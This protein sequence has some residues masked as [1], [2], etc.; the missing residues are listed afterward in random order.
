M[1]YV[2]QIMFSDF[3]RAAPLVQKGQHNKLWIH[4]QRQVYLLEL[5]N[6]KLV[7]NQRVPGGFAIM[8]SGIL[9]TST[10]ARAMIECRY[11]GR[12][13]ASTVYSISVQ[14]HVLDK[15]SVPVHLHVS[16]TDHLPVQ[17]VHVTVLASTQLLQ[18][19]TGVSL[20]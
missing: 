8:T 11:G 15:Y 18:Y 19:N 4:F 14:L 20:W 1:T 10:K 9:S 7:D 5:N 12:V 13:A 2:C 3:S 16:P 17:T 6:K